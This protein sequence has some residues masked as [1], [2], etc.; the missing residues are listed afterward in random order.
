MSAEPQQQHDEKQVEEKVLNIASDDMEQYL[1][2]ILGEEIYGI[3][4]L[5]IQ[6]IRGWENATPLPNVP[7]YVKGVINMRGA[8]V[9]IIDLRERFNFQNV[10]YDDSTVVIITKFHTEDENGGF[11]E[12]TV[13][14]VVDGVSD[15][16]D[17]DP[18]TLQ[19]TPSFDTGVDRIDDEFIKG[20]AVVEQSEVQQMLIVLNV[21][22]MLGDGVFDQLKAM[23]QT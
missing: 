3:D 9:P 8:V 4:I 12:K 22:V 23:K 17:V 16:E 6:E 1:S 2:F 19:K 10:T 11:K 18:S 20:L 15:V 21:D 13:G 14:L 7:H 5:R